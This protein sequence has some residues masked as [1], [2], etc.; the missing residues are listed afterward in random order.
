MN[1]WYSTPQEAMVA[2]LNKQ[3]EMI[4]VLHKQLEY[5]MTTIS[6]RFEDEFYYDI[7]EIREEVAR[8]GE[9]K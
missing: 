1:K 5:V 3:Q 9:K 2:D 4:D 6:D 8:I 7:K